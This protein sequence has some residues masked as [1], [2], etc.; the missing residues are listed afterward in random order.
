[1]KDGAFYDGITLLHANTIYKDY[2]RLIEPPSIFG[3]IEKKYT[4]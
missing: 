2:S 3:Q 1:M 4:L